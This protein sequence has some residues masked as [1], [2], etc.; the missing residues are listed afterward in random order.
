[1]AKKII[2]VDIDEVLSPYVTGL[3]GWHNAK[4]GTQLQFNDFSSYEFHRVWGG[5]LEAA[6]AKSDEYFENRLP[7]AAQ[8]LEN[9]QQALSQLKKD[10][11]LIVVTSRKLVHKPQT[12]S[13]I[14]NI[15][16]TIFKKL[17]SVITGQMTMGRE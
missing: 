13:W 1:M 11:D 17:S 5:V 15:S 7:A 16:P 10:Y 8:P 14:Q 9:A 2:A 3:V 4:Y 12:I 6:V